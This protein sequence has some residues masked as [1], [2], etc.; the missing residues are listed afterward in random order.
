MHRIPPANPWLQRSLTRRNLRLIQ[1]DRKSK[2]PVLHII[3]YFLLNTHRVARDRSRSLALLEF[4]VGAPF[5]DF[6]RVFLSVCKHCILA[7]V[8]AE[9]SRSNR[10][11]VCKGQESTP[12]VRNIQS[13][14]VRICWG[15]PWQRFQNI[16]SLTFP[17][18]TWRLVPAESLLDTQSPPLPRCLLQ[19]SRWLRQVIVFQV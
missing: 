19:M 7:C 15:L 18:W 6:T 1:L 17:C 3:L 9:L 10:N 16:S 8:P 2:I 11:T 12:L 4:Q 14:E 13:Y 5:L